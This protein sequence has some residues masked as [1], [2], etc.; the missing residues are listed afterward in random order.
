VTSTLYRGGVLPAAP[1]PTFSDRTADGVSPT[2][3]LV[4]DGVVAWLGG[5]DEADGLV[6]AA[7]EVVHLEGALV[8]PGF[9]DAHAELLGTALRL[10]GVELGDATGATDVLARVRAAVQGPAGRLL[11]AEGAPLT[12]W[13]GDWGGDWST[14]QDE[15]RAPTRA[16]LDAAA[17]GAPV[18]LAAA[19]PGVAVVSTSFAQ[20]L[21]LPGLS[22]WRE[23]GLV[24][25]AAHAA[26]LAALR[27]ATGARR[28]RLDRLAL[29]ALARA[30]VVAVHEHSAPGSDSRAGLAGLLRRTA[31]PASGLPRVV[32]YRAE[33]CETVDDAREV[34]AAVPG[35]TGIGSLAVDGLLGD[36]TA[37]LR[38]PY[39]DSP[40]GWAY[41][42]GRLE[43]DAGQIG[44]HVAAVTRAGLQAEFR[45]VGDRAMDE[46]LLGLRV[47]ADVEGLDAVRARGH[48]LELASMLDA[49]ALATLV[50]LGTTVVLQPAADA[51][52]GMGGECGEGGAAGA[53]G[54]S[55]ARLG[56]GRAASLHPVADLV[57]AGV[58]V[59]FGSGSPATPVDPW[60]GVA[61][62]V[63]NPTPDQRI[64]MTAAL[65]AHARGGW[66]AAGLGAAGDGLLRVGAPAHLAVWRTAGGLPSS[67]PDEAAPVCLR[68]VRA[69]VVLH[70]ALG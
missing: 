70:D 9:V 31:D 22:G 42:A 19:D 44:N 35:L 62:A 51:D 59:A 45:V 26:A 10:D 24:T 27:E 38:R 47:A 54:W 49:P 55:A 25:G 20:V 23:D 4:A 68:T 67:G 13:G 57:A 40:A 65:A 30:G 1:A 16:E 43:L 18:L 5:E 8:T 48:R 3:L 17:G 11:S 37:A 14:G 64:G 29:D 46:V 58:P 2:A 53:G 41:P 12:G 60:A 7:D 63:R 52:W 34:A 33:L 39:T 21:G 28:D 66:L 69:G 6:D 15:R 32:G 36:R 61:A 56:P 50:L